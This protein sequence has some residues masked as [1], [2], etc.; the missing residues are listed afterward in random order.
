[1]R[2]TFNVTLIPEKSKNLQNETLFF[3]Q[4]FNLI[5]KV[6]ISVHFEFGKVI[7][8][9]NDLNLENWLNF[10]KHISISVLIIFYHLSPKIRN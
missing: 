2:K 10:T 4:Q 9:L 8:Q 3:F 1:M 6:P 5:P 7:F